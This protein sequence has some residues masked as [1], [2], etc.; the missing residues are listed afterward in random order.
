MSGRSW[1]KGLLASGVKQQNLN[2]GDSLRSLSWSYGG[3]TNNTSC[4]RRV[5]K[6]IL[7]GTTLA[8]AS[9][10]ESIS[11]C[12]ASEADD[13]EEG[14][15]WREEGSK[16]GEEGC[17][18]AALQVEPHELPLYYLPYLRCFLL[19]ARFVCRV[20]SGSHFNTR[21]SVGEEEGEKEMEE[22]K[23]LWGEPKEEKDID[24][25]VYA[26]LSSIRDK[27]KVSRMLC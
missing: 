18:K 8:R 23:E 12:S 20:Q 21:D 11:S 16:G 14:A 4:T 6:T 19:S 7:G 9:H 25:L 1:L 2:V 17:V 24:L 27:L 13:E 15:G 5:S 10:R 26:E 3:E 22:R